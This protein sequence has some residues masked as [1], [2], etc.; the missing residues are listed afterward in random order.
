MKTKTIKRSTAFMAILIAIL[1]TICSLSTLVGCGGNDDGDVGT[2][3]LNKTTLELV[4]GAMET[5]TA[6]TSKENVTVIWSSSDKTIATVSRGRVTGVK[7]G[8]ATI[9]ASL[10]DDVYAECVV[11]VKEDERTI[12]LDK[13]EVTVD[14]AETSSLT[15]TAT[16]SDS[17]SV[18]WTS[19]NS[20]VATVK[21]GVV[22]FL[23]TAQKTAQVTVTAKISG[24]NKSATCNITVNNSAIPDDYAQL[25]KNTSKVSLITDEDSYQYFLKNAHTSRVTFADSVCGGN[26][27]YIANGAVVFE[28][29][30]VSTLENDDTQYE[31]RYQPGAK[32][33]LA[34]GDLYTVTFKIDTNVGGKFGFTKGSGKV[35]GYGS[36]IPDDNEPEQIL[37]AGVSEITLTNCLVDDDS[38]GAGDPLALR[39]YIFEM[40]E[41]GSNLVIKFYDFKFTKTGHVDEIGVVDPTGAYTVSKVSNDAG[42]DGLRNQWGYFQQGSSVTAGG[43]VTDNNGTVDGMTITFKGYFAGGGAE[44]LYYQTSKAAGTEAAVSFKISMSV[45]GTIEF[46]RGVS[47]VESLTLAA[48]EVKDVEFNYTVSEQAIR[49]D[50][51]LSED[52]PEDGVTITITEFSFEADGE[53]TPETYA[54]QK[55]NNGSNAME[56]LVD[57]WGYYQAKAALEAGGSVANNVGSADGMTVTF[58][59]AFLGTAERLYYVSSIAEGKSV[60]VKFKISANVDATVSFNNSSIGGGTSIGALTAN[61]PVEVE[62]TYTVVANEYNYIQLNLGIS[63]EVPADGVTFT[64]TDFSI[65]AA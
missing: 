19:S 38:K 27:P 40:P 20:S 57:Q 60:T 34:Q 1:M 2:I 59:D 64:I 6:S 45:A 44:R 48:N 58:K 16:V 13:T 28:L 50:I 41:D 21:D 46:K 37:E 39:P 25:S 17:S 8:S 36:N 51:T 3:T 10:S 24:S 63:G 54:V 22:T 30:A 5:L 52:L 23:K 11:T 56:K 26:L 18:E 42:A 15:L 61:Q 33:G 43:S 31:L 4:E 9:K 32:V 7:A 14:I 65:V 53:E 35:K 55:V 29:S 62:F 47:G 49:L 12:T